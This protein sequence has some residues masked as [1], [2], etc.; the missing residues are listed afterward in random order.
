MSASDTFASFEEFISRIQTLRKQRRTKKLTLRGKVSR[1]SPAKSKKAP[2]LQK[3]GGRCHICGGVI[4][5][6]WQADHVLAHA[7][8]GEHAPDNY[9]PAH[10]ICNK[11]RWFYGM[12]EFQWILKLGVWLRTEIERETDCGKLAAK[13]FDLPPLTGTTFR[14]RISGGANQGRARDATREEV[15]GGADHREAPR[16]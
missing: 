6:K 16:G 12:E 3:T 14:E 11:Y 7:L 10:P 13:Q 15:H 2:I 1:K 9:L 5:G 4:D 8:G